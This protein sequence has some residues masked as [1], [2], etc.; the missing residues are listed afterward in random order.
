MGDNFFSYLQ[1]LELMAFFSGYPLV[2]AIILSIA[3][4]KQLRNNFKSSIVR[5]LPYSYALVGILYLG[6]Q[7]K[8]L[9]PDYSAENIK[10]ALEHPFLKIWGLLSLLFWIPTLAKK[11]ELSLLHSLVFFFLLLKDLIVQSSFNEGNTHIIKND[12][13]VYTDSLM[14][15]ISSLLVVSITYFLYQW[16]RQNSKPHHPQ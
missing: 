13:K 3:G 10:I 15:N 2:Y 8:N 9:Y 12:M 16:I 7:L 5:L 11:T 6:L 14:I 4:K 1:Q